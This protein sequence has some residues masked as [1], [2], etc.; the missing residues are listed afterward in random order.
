MS[1]EPAAR[2]AARRLAGARAQGSGAAF[3]T[4]LARFIFTPMTAR[5][6]L[7]RFDKL[8]PPG[9][10]SWD[11]GRQRAV[12]V[13]IGVGGGDWL[14]LAPGGRLAVI[15]GQEPVMR[16]T[17]VTRVADAS[18]RTAQPWDTIAPRLRNFPEPSR[19]SF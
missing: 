8:D 11:A 5:A 10:P 1:P 9:R 6:A 12:M 3:E 2:R 14:L 4:W 16:A 15:A 19:F 17:F 18:Y 13:P 7:V